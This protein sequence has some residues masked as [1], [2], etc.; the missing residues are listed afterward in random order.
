MDPFG[1][2]VPQKGRHGSY[3]RNVQNNLRF[4]GQYYDQETGLHQNWH[5]DY[6]PKLG[7]YVE[8][9]PIGLKGGTNT[10]VYVLNNPT[11]LLDVVGY[12]PG[13]LFTSA[14]KAIID[15]IDYSRLKPDANAKEYCGW[16]LQDCDNPG[17]FLYKEPTPGTA[18]VCPLGW[19]PENS[20]KAWYHTH[21][22]DLPFWVFRDPEEFSSDDAGVC[23]RSKSDGYLGTPKGRIYKLPRTLTRSNWRD[24]I[25]TIR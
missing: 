23:F 13:A 16:I 15:A 3:I 5:R 14:E 1:N 22:S 17:K 8:T 12:L 21:A 9:D 6:D 18:T 25:E 11:N 19:P 10:Y 20:A 2:V 24:L 7:R 4:P